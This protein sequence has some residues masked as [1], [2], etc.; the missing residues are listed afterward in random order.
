MNDVKD[1]QVQYGLDLTKA[2]EA[3]KLIKNNF[4]LA[5]VIADDMSDMMY[6]LYDGH[7]NFEH[8]PYNSIERENNQQ[9]RETQ[10]LIRALGKNR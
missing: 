2:N 5:F 7:A 4:L 10:A 6:V 1:I 8:Y 9:A 3:R